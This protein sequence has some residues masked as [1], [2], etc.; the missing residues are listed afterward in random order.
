LG[1]LITLEGPEGAGKSTQCAALVQWLKKAGY[2]PVVTREPGGTE[3]GG[4]IRRILLETDLNISAKAEMLLYAADR[5]QH[6]DQLILPALEKGQ[7]VICDR[8][9]DS[10]MA[11]QGYARG[12]GIEFVERVNQLSVGDVV[13]DL[14][15]LFDLPVEEGMGRKSSGNLDRI[16][17]E[18]LEFHKRVRE[19]YLKIAEQEPERVKIIDAV[20]DAET[21]TRKVIETIAS[22]LGKQGDGSLASKE[23]D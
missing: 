15:L 1:K 5:A 18:T 3:L 11:Y 17:K 12:L 14:T 4:R 7:I 10:T 6:V 16:E 2:D 20:E 19:G 22:L 23:K 8:Y 9:F 21:V 13:P